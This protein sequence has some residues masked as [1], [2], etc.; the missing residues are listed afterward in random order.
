[1]T[2]LT[3]SL[4]DMQQFDFVKLNDDFKEEVKKEYKNRKIKID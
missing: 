1:M 3:G 2:I 4:C